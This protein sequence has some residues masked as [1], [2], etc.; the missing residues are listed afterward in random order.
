MAKEKMEVEIETQEEP[1]VELE[2][3]DEVV[4]EPQEEPEV[5]IETQLTDEEIEAQIAEALPPDPEPVLLKPVTEEKLQEIEEDE[6]VEFRIS[7][8]EQTHSKIVEVIKVPRQPADA[9]DR[10]VKELVDGIALSVN[11][12][13]VIQ[14]NT[15]R[16]EWYLRSVN[17]GSTKSRKGFK[18]IIVTRT[19]YRKA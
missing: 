12:A 5:E 2:V 6:S 13:P 14:S 7:V 8:E 11:G 9:P 19:Y 3:E 10:S 18:T 4:V 16:G 17:Y 1:E 15:G